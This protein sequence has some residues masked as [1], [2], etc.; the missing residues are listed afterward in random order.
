MKRYAVI[1]LGTLPVLAFGSAAS[2]QTP[3]E[4]RDLIGARA[5]SAETAIQSRG[6]VNV[7]AETGDDRVWT[8][9]WNQRTRTCVTVAT[10]NGRYDSITTSPAPDCRQQ[11]RPL[12]APVPSR[13]S[14]ATR[15]VP[16]WTHEEIDLGLV[17][18]G[19]GQ[20][21]TAATRWGYSWDYDKDR[22]VYGNRTELTK[23]D[24]DASVTIQLWDGG[25]RIRLPKKLIPPINSRGDHGWWALSDV[26]MARDTI[27]AGYRLNGLNKPSITIDRRSGRISIRGTGDYAFRGTCDL[28]GADDHPRF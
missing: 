19:E 21:P 17:C 6:Y 23:E 15:P 13:P 14:E 9:W 4:L 16:S 18:Y 2:A 22:Y 12:P 20:R 26:S 10:V 8:Y 27:R 24:F 28:I 1:V 3:P 7:R 25:G 5:A 11:G